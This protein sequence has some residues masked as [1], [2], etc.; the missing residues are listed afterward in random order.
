MHFPQDTQSLQLMAYVALTLSSIIVASTSLFIAYRQNF[1]WRPIVFASS[2]GG[3]GGKYGYTASIDFEFW[4]RKKYPVAIRFVSVTYEKQAMDRNVQGVLSNDWTIDNE[5]RVVS[6]KHETID[7]SRT[8]IYE[9]VVPVHKSPIDLEEDVKIELFYFDPIKAKIKKI[10]VHTRNTLY[11]ETLSK[12]ERRAY[13]LK[14]W[15]RLSGLRW[16]CA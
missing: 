10:V 1:G 7:P 9:L 6:H 4:N 13:R 12:A 16:L 2:Y 15:K 14:F 3:G 8:R 11:L 5:H